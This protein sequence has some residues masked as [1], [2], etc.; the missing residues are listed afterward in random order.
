MLKNPILESLLKTATPDIKK[1][2]FDVE[3][4]IR[5][6][7]GDGNPSAKGLY[8]RL[9]INRT[10]FLTDPEGKAIKFTKRLYNTNDI[11]FIDEGTWN[12]ILECGKTS[13]GNEYA[14]TT[15]FESNN[16]N[17][18]SLNYPLPYSNI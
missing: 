14:Y 11:S 16:Q 9:G 13:G 2:I 5:N 3:G 10:Q 4:N 15:A 12:I 7:Y 8:A 17:Q 18:D 6:I 1:N